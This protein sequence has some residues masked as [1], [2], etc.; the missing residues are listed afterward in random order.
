MELSKTFKR[1]GL[2]VTDITVMASLAVATLLAYYAVFGHQFILNW[3]DYNY[4]VNNAAIQGVDLNNL[5]SIFSDFF[6][7]NYAPVHLLSYI[8]DYLIWNLNPH[9]YHVSN[10]LI[11]ILNGFLIYR[12]FQALKIEALPALF[13]AA[14]FLLHPVQVESVAWVS[15]RKNLLACCFFLLAMLSYLRFKNDK[16]GAARHYASSLVFLTLALLSKSI[17]VVFP[18]V[19]ICHDL[20]FHSAAKRRIKI[21]GYLPYLL[22]AVIAG[23]LA[24]ISQTPEI[25][26]GRREYPGGS[27]ISTIWTMAPV[28]VA[29]MKDIFYP[30]ELSPYYMVTIRPSADA[31]AICSLLV[32][33]GMAV[34]LIKSF[35]LRPRLFFFAMIFIISLL[36]VLQII[37]ILT[38]KN[39][40]YLYLPMIGVAGAG[41]LLLGRVLRAGFRV[42]MAALTTATVICIGCG[43]VTHYQSQGWYDEITLWNAALHKDPENILAWLM[44]TKGYT[45]RGD[46]ASAM[47]ALSTY[48]A[49]KLKYGPLR[50]WEGLGA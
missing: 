39:D 15:E 48:N 5:K 20:C 38:L 23:I 9:G 1:P 24:M 12:L 45:S 22:L 19:V 30:L 11:H 31:V 4:V 35:K 10:V 50:G 26:G 7:G 2:S 49:L 40:R 29:Y 17:A 18:L 46:G 37:P 44:L 25:G 13:G 42:R 6:V 33:G 27:V 36:P 21:A 16:A 32:L 41:A 14:L 43:A 8:P 34:F 3:D 28:L 47:R